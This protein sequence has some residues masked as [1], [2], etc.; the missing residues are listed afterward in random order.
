M[1]QCS[2]ALGSSQ[3]LSEKGI[4]MTPEQMMKLNNSFTN[5]MMDTHAVMSIRMMDMMGAIPTDADEN[6]KMVSEKG[7]AF[8]E[9]MSALTSAALSG[10]RPDQI[11]AAGLEPLQREV[12]SNRA[13]LEK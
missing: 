8:A 13:R 5:L 3:L 4:A 6:T 10:Y 2:I 11:M 12:S 9:A 7:P 1:L